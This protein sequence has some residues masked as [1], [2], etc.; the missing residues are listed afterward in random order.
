MASSNSPFHAGERQVQERLGVRDEIEPWARKVVRA[1]LPGDHRQFY[2][3]LPFLVVAARDGGGRPWATILA[4]EPG[5]VDS[6]DDTALHIGALPVPGDALEAAFDRDDDVGLLGIE[7]HTRRRNRA[8]GRVRRRGPDGL[9][10]RLDQTYGNCPQYIHER[11]WSRAACREQPPARRS[12]ASFTPALRDRIESADTFFIASGYR[13]KGDDPTFGMDASHRGGDPG[14][15]RVEGPRS[16]I[17]PDYAGNKHFNTLGNLLLDP[18]A[19]LLFVDFERGSL[20]QLTGHARID[21]DSPEIAG[22]PGARR[23]VRFELDEA[24]VLEDALPLRWGPSGEGVRDLRVAAKVRESDDVT[25]FVL[26]SRDGGPMPGF[27]AG[28]HLPVEF[29]L[30][31]VAAPAART[32]SLSGDPAASHYRISVKREDR[33]QVSRHLHDRVEVGQIV[34]SRAPRGEF[35]LHLEHPR[36]VVL[37]SAGVGLTP[38]VSMLHDLAARNDARPVWFV[39]GA[40]DGRHH[41]LSEEVQRLTDAGPHLHRHTAYSRPRAQ[42]RPGRD[43]DAVGRIDGQALAEQLPDLDADFYLCGP[44]SFMASLQQDLEDRGVSPESIHTESFGPSA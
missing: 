44:V 39:H 9:E 19:G 30:P 36:P 11:A 18:R 14:F 40:R 3:Q 22:F 37:V 42:D 32:Y 17:F 29:K 25:S 12:H 26:E 10:L 15:V 33:G 23:L 6:P 16:L 38:L 27:S 21:W 8:N 5:F 34:S 7:L 4:G 24:V 35:V 41:P 43:F 1:R 2:A 28:Q 31:G 20:V 13:G